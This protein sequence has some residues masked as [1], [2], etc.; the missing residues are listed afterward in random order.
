MLKSPPNKKVLFVSLS[1]VRMFFRQNSHVLES[2]TSI[3]KTL[4]LFEISTETA[5]KMKLFVLLLSNSIERDPIASQLILDHLKKNI[6]IIAIFRVNPASLLSSLLPSPFTLKYI[7][8]PFVGWCIIL[9][10]DRFHQMDQEWVRLMKLNQVCPLYLTLPILSD[11]LF[12]HFL[13]LV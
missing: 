3:W 9:P 6:T 8:H 5:F 13:Q 2:W 7:K 11:T 10:W 12:Y 4:H 1:V